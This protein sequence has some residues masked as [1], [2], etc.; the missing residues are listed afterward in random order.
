MNPIDSK[1]KKILAMI[2]GATSEGEA[3]AA[4][5]A[6]QRLL[7]ANNMTI[8]DID[9][10]DDAPDVNEYAEDLGKRVPEWVKVLAYV[11]AKNYR[12][13]Y[14][15][16]TSHGAYD[17]WS[18]RHTVTGSRFVFV[19][20]SQDATVAA[21]CFRATKHAIET[22]FKKFCGKRFEQN[23]T[24]IGRR[25]GVKNSYCLG[26][27]QGLENSY[28]EQLEQDE[29]M[30][31]AIVV[32]ESVNRYMNDELNCKKMK[33]RPLPSPPITQSRMPAGKTVTASVRA[34]VSHPA[35][36]DRHQIGEGDALPIHF[37]YMA[38]GKLAPIWVE[39]V[40][41]RTDRIRQNA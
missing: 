10:D 37:L 41:Y 18:G 16:Q 36:S 14:Y 3:R 17:Y 12:C 5:L 9:L 21:G 15:M 28:R 23:G 27:I 35:H 26:F 1:L 24:K 11:I 32:P 30:A 22:C 20:E 6:L 40:R 39:L 2:D 34:T 4:S 38:I 29:T 19:G 25:A 33:P 8:D 7:A 31:L 13:R